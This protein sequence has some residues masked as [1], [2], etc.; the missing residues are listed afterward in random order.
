MS[1]PRR[2]LAGTGVPRRPTRALADERRSGGRAR[3]LPATASSCGVRK[4][5][6]FET[7]ERS[8][9]PTRRGTTRSAR[10]SPRHSGRAHGAARTQPRPARRRERRTRLGGQRARTAAASSAPV[11]ADVKAVARRTC[12][13]DDVGASRL[14]SAWPQPRHRHL[15]RLRRLVAAAAGPHGPRRAAI[16]RARASLAWRSS[17]GEQRALLRGAELNRPPVVA[18]LERPEDQGAPS[19]PLP[20]RETRALN[21]LSTTP[22]ARRQPAARMLGASA[23]GRIPTRRRRDENEHR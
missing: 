7:R 4:P 21:R 13:D 5:Q 6:R 14:A 23:E 19:P 3:G 20:S 10:G 16:R 22:Q 8:A 12:V 17:S 15:Q 2:L 9:R 1:W 11:C 18:S